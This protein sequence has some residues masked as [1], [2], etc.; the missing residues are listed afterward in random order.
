MTSGRTSG[1]V[2]TRGVT[3]G[4][5]ARVTTASGFAVSETSEISSSSNSGLIIGIVIGAFVV[6]G[7]KIICSSC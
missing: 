3:T 1:L 4:S 7:S 6:L 5:V 2:T